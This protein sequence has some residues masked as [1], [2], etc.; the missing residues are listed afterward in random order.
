[1]LIQVAV[2]VIIN[3][4]DEVFISRRSADQHQGNKWEFPG[5]KV[6]ENETV[7][8]ALRREIKEELGIDVQSQTYLIG[9]THEYD[10]K[11]VKLE[12]FEIRDWTGEPSGMEG[13]PTRWI[14]RENLCDVEFPKANKAIVGLLMK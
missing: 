10:T 8:D 2:A 6:E 13:Q 1:M 5:G 11:R 9:I 4:K 14:K 3:D 12:V 7:E